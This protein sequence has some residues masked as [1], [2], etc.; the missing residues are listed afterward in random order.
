LGFIGTA[1]QSTERTQN[2]NISRLEMKKTILTLAAFLVASGT[3]FAGNRDGD[4]APALKN[5]NRHAVTIVHNVV[6]APK[7]ASQKVR[8]VGDAAKASVVVN[9][10]T[11]SLSKRVA[12]GGRTNRVG[13]SS[14]G[15]WQQ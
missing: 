11:S 2:E 14:R 7:D 13:N 1:L 5:D 6:T 3:A 4:T 8:R 10:P 9:V 12:V 15:N